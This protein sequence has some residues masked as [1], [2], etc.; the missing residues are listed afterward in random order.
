MKITRVSEHIWSVSAWLV[1][2]ITV[3]LVKE[4]DG[5]TLVD[6]GMP[7]MAKGIAGAVKPLGI[8]PLRRIVLTHGHSDHVGAIRRLL[9]ES[10]G[11]PVVSRA[12][13]GA[14]WWTAN[15]SCP[16]RPGSRGRQVRAGPRRL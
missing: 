2:P 5:A 10:P 1:F 16:S 14:A 7:F 13:R 11:V 15:R 12:C 4:E 8:G 9:L 3:W 6:A